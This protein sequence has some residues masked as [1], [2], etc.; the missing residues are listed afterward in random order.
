VAR[1][2]ER[3]FADD[4]SDIGEAMAPAEYFWGE[5]V[6]VVMAHKDVNRLMRIH[7][8]EQSGCIAVNIFP[9]IKN[10]MTRFCLYPEAVMPYICYLHN[11]SAIL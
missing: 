9:K 2:L 8:L 11:V 5:M 3:V 4:V 1:C 6:L 7:Q 10:D